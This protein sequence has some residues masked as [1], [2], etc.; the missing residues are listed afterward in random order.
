MLR[1]FFFVSG[2]RG[3]LGY[4]S[5]MADGRLQRDGRQGFCGWVYVERRDASGCEGVVLMRSEWMVV[6]RLVVEHDRTVE[7]GREME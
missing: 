5:M 1:G 3:R 6:M 4:D 7:R 2:A